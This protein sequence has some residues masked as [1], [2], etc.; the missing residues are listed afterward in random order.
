MK[1]E[2]SRYNCKQ[3]ELKVKRTH[4]FKVSGRLEYRGFELPGFDCTMTRFIWFVTA[5]VQSTSTM[6]QYHYES[7]G[8]MTIKYNNSFHLVCA[9]YNDSF[10]LVCF[11]LSAMD[12]S[13]IAMALQMFH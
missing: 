10:Q 2:F 9:E 5:M 6:T 4:S 3:N 7:V 11:F 8:S 13:T 12:Q 1:F